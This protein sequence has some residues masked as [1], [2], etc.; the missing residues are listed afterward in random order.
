MR[1]SGVRFSEA[2]PLEGPYLLGRVLLV[3]RSSTASVTRVSHGPC[4]RAPEG[5]IEGVS[6]GC[7]TLGLGVAVDLAHDVFVVPVPRG[8]HMIGDAGIPHRRTDECL[9]MCSVTSGTPAARQCSRH[10]SPPGES[11]CRQCPPRDGRN[12]RDRHQ[13]QRRALQVRC[14]RTK[15]PGRKATSQLERRARSYRSRRARVPGLE[16]NHFLGTAL[17]PDRERAQ[18]DGTPSRPPCAAG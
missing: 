15:F 4:A 8:D 3:R 12:A 1:R 7:Q 11:A 17:A 14:W 9:A 2:A 16:L 6:S 5:P 10:R 13:R 18:S